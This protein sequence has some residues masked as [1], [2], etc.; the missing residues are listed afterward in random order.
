MQQCGLNRLSQHV[1]VYGAGLEPSHTSLPSPMSFSHGNPL[2]TFWLSKANG[3][4]SATMKKNS[5]FLLNM[6]C[7][8]LKKRE[9]LTP[10]LAQSNPVSSQDETLPSWNLSEQV[11][12][13][14]GRR[15]WKWFL[16]WKWKEKCRPSVDSY[17]SADE[18]KLTK[19]LSYGYLSILC[20]TGIS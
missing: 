18:I 20:S 10:I 11:T 17:C 7:V 15:D 6:N 3:G 2:F 8:N 19:P 14:W 13:R 16:H 12:L 9:T 4:G 5:T 1:N